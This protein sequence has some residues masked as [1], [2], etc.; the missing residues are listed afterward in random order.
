MEHGF[1]QTALEDVTRRRTERAASKP[2]D[3]D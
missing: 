1:I 2:E 3:N